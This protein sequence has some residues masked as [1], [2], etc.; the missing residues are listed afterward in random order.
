M[1]QIPSNLSSSKLIQLIPKS[2]TVKISDVCMWSSPC[3]HYIEITSDDD[4]RYWGELNSREIR[5]ILK[6]YPDVHNQCSI[7]VLTHIF[8][9]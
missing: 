3:Q 1:E 2:K 4:A 9:V 5:K 7:D 8:D 6:R